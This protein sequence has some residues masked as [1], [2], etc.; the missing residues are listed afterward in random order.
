M[1]HCKR[2]NSN[3][4]AHPHHRQHSPFQGGHAFLCSRQRLG[5]RLRF[6][7]NASL[8]EGHRLAVHFDVHEREGLRDFHVGRDNG[9]ACLDGAEGA[10]LV[11][12]CAIRKWLDFNNF[13]GAASLTKGNIVVSF[14]RYVKLAI[15]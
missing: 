3:I 13:H 10:R 7:H 9:S 4:D 5:V 8:H 12:V 1:M 11:A 15:C 2:I 6:R 14:S